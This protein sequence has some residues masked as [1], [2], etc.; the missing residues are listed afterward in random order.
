MD[1]TKTDEG[2][3]APDSI[4]GGLTRIRFHNEATGD[5]ALQLVRLKDGATLEE[6]QAAFG[7]EDFNPSGNGIGR[8]TIAAGGI[9]NT[10]A[11]GTTEVV[12]DLEP[13]R[14]APVSFLSGNT[15]TRTFEVT[16]APAVPSATPEGQVTVKMLE[17]AYDGAP[18]VLPAGTTTVEVVNEGEQLHEMAVF[19]VNGD[20]VTAQQVSQAHNG[21]PAPA[22]LSYAAVG[23]MGELMP[24]DSGWATLNLD[25]GV[26]V[27]RC[28]VFDRSSGEAGQL[29]WVLGMHHSFTVE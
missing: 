7:I 21:T 26:Y 6:F 10:A 2:F 8:L 18:D 15:S 4:P 19:R 12:L 11:G 3:E 23:G 17:F 27:L 28:R 14:Y 25:P 20:G 29:H 13:G 24:G 5:D 22:A 1:I 16:A 9:A